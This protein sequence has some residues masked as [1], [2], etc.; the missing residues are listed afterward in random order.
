MKSILQLLKYVNNIKKQIKQEMFFFVTDVLYNWISQFKI[1]C[2]NVCRRN[3][4]SKLLLKRFWHI[5]PW[6]PWPLTPKSIGFL[7]YPGQMCGPSFRSVDQGIHKL[8]I[9][10]GF[11]TFDPGDLGLW[12]SDHKINKVLLLPR[13]DVWTSLRRVG[14]GVVKL[15]RKR[16]GKDLPMCILWAILLV[17]MC[18]WAYINP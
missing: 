4:F 2:T 5:S 1:S 13:M 10:N 11:G 17:Q 18:L 15:N 8:L 16:K 3:S 14:Q 9:G 7:C 12:P 6:W